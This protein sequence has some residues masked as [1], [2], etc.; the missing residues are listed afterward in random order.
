MLIVF[1][2]SAFAAE[3]PIKLTYFNVRGRGEAIRL[4]FE[5]NG[6]DY[7]NDIVD[8]SQWPAIKK[9]G[10]ADGSLPFGQLP[11][12][13][14]TDGTTIVQSNAILRRIGREWDLYGKKRYLTDMIMEAVEDWRRIFITLLYQ[15]K[16]AKEKLEEYKMKLNSEFNEETGGV[17]GG[18]LTQFE[19]LYRREGTL[20]FGGIAPSIADYDLY[21]LIEMNMCFIDDFLANFKDL[22]FWFERMSARRFIKA[23]VHADKPWRARST[24]AGVGDCG[25]NTGANTANKS[26]L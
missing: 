8:K 25:A 23:Y 15:D 17:K 12:F 21:T 14:T 18:I 1:F 20:Y 22:D 10:I 13:T 2:I 5:D 11:R 9:S 24:G 3:A 19:L 26:E 6:I 7:D 4:A 16:L